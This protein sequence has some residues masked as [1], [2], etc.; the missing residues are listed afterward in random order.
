MLSGDEIRLYVTASWR[1]ML[2]K[3]DA[4]RSFNF[5]ADG[6]WDS[7]LAIL[8]AAPALMIGWVSRIPILFPTSG[9]QAGL[10]LRLAI[11][12]IGVWVLPLVAFGLVAPHVG[13]ADRFTRYVVVTN[14]ASVILAWIML[15]SALVSLVMPGVPGVAETVSL[16]VFI[17]TMVL[18]WRVTNLSIDKGTATGTAVY[19]AMFVTSLVV[20]FTL[21]PLLG[22]MATPAA[23]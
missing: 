1:L 2:G 11:V 3:P 4:M 22:V 10:V 17:I 7:F 12:E 23:P 14:W 21:Q 16:L 19:V 20:L 6:F 8:V 13:L 5:S 18:V 9:G 15:P